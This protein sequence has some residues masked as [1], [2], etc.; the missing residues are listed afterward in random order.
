MLELFRW[1]RLELFIA[2]GEL[3]CNTSV[4]QSLDPASHN[5]SDGAPGGLTLTDRMLALVFAAISNFTP[6]PLAPDDPLLRCG[7]LVLTPHHADHTPEGI[8][9]LNAGAVDNVI[10]YFEGR[11]TNRIV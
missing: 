10:A 7:H 6:P 4:M 11:D 5:L 2:G 3:I 9:L 8:E 1:N